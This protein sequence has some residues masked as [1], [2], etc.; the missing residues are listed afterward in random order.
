MTTPPKKMPKGGRKG[1]TTFPRLRLN[2]SADFA[3]KLVSK[4]HTTAL[5]ADVILP[6]VFG[7]SG[8]RGKVKASALKQ[9]GLLGGTPEAYSA[10]DL[11][12][13]LSAAPADEKSPYLIQAFNGVKLFKNLIDTFSGDSVSFAKIK[14][15]ALNFKVHPD[16]ADECVTRFTGSAVDAGLARETGDEFEFLSIEQAVKNNNGDSSSGEAQDN[17]AIAESV[18]GESDNPTSQTDAPANP[19]HSM[20]A[21]TSTNGKSKATLELKIDPSMDPERLE[22]HL[23]IL[24]KY[25]LI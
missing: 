1:G 7:N 5:A 13:N 11:A 16:V 22:K 6:G 15:Q 25:G 8:P 21:P 10:T 24:K 17:E 2:E 14:Q 3:A 23:G 18:E 12:K 4:T 9:Y 19:Q 20:P